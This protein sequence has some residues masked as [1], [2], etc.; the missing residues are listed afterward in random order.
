MKNEFILPNLGGMIFGL[1]NH[2]NKVEV[3]HHEFIPQIWWDDHIPRM[4]TN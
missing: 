3:V 4:S 2:S 1:I